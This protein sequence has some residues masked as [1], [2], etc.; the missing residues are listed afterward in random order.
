MEEAAAIVQA[1]GLLIDPALKNEL[2]LQVNFEITVNS[3]YRFEDSKD[4][5]VDQRTRFCGIVETVL[6]HDVLEEKIL[7]V[8]NRNTGLTPTH[9]LLLSCRQDFHISPS[10]RIPHISTSCH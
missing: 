4:R 9:V 8:I 3:F 5:T 2:V 7:A 10:G 1:R 6:R